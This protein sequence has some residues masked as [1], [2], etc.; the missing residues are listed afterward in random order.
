MNEHHPSNLKDQLLKDIRSGEVAM[1]PRYFFLLKIVALASVATAV[2]ILSV[3]IFN[4]ILF[5]L[6]IN[7]HQELLG[8]GSRG[9]F[10]FL[11]VFPWFLLL[12]DVALVVLLEYLLRRFKFG[13][14]VPVLYLLAGLFV[15]TLLAGFAVD[16]GTYF[17][18]RMLEGSRHL[19]PG[20]GHFYEGAR[21]P[22]PPGGGLC[23]CTI[24]AI[25][26]SQLTVEDTRSGT[27]TL[28]VLLPSNNPRATTTALKVGDTVLIAGTE[29]NGVIRAFGVRKISEENEWLRMRIER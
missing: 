3:F 10:T 22:P 14:K 25:D 1:R 9:L 26:G 11:R 24:L 28:V 15:G 27:T 16:R 18:D 17:N 4:F 20:L 13:Y 7:H 2:L 6:R 19:P 23:R 8:F 5:G 21:R 12:L 29:E